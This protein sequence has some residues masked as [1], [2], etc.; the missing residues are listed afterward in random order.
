MKF[1]LAIVVLIVIAVIG[2]VVMA[3]CP[4]DKEWIGFLIFILGILG[5]ETAL[6]CWLDWD[7]RCRH[8]EDDEDND[9]QK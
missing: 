5:G 1:K 6:F 3:V 8:S 9:K 7:Y 4:A 2:V